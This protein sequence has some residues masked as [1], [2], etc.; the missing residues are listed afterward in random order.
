MNRVI[1]VILLFAGIFAGVKAFDFNDD[2]LNVA[3]RIIAESVLLS[4]DESSF[5]EQNNK[6][7]S[8]EYKFANYNYVNLKKQIIT[9]KTD[10]AKIELN[11]NNL[12]NTLQRAVLFSML[13]LSEYEKGNISKY[14]YLI[15]EAYNNITS[16]HPVIAEKYCFEIV[17]MLMN[18]DG[19]IT[20]E[21]AVDFLLIP[22]YSND[23]VLYLYGMGNKKYCVEKFAR[24][25]KDNDFVIKNKRFVN[26]LKKTIL[27]S[28]IKGMK[29]ED[30]ECN[31]LYS[32]IEFSMSWKIKK[33]NNYKFPLLAYVF[34]VGGDYARYK[35]YR[36]KSISK[37]QLEDMRAS[38]FGYV[39][40]ASKIF[41]LTNEANL[42]IELLSTLPESH[43]K[44]KL[45]KNLL[46]LIPQDLESYKNISL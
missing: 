14:N 4:G 25:L 24:L 40:Y 2:N 6:I 15:F 23:Q 1:S 36:D 10:N 31:F 46:L 33:W 38:Y 41:F 9:Q 3:R 13:A 28:K 11:I 42:A 20:Q 29:D 7:T 17:K 19:R 5:S 34:Y 35:I 30:V 44:N 32:A 8:D 12:Q 26:Y 45:I 22:Y 37:E 18:T 16:V 21:H 43:T 39:E 27:I